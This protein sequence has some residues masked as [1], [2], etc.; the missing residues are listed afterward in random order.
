MN[1]RSPLRDVLGLG[2]AKEGAK[3][4]WWQRVT[5][6][7]LALL[8]VWF[9]ASLICL[10]SLEYA[11][12]TSWIGSPFTTTFLS[13]FIVTLALHSQ[14]GVQ[15]VIEDY[16]HGALKTASIVLS[17]FCHII[18]ATLG[19]VSVLRIAFGSAA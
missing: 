9:V 15:V 7:G 10:G 17:N 18:V 5:A 19:V 12:I 8:G 11:A 14:L 1:L 6:I 3:H 4:W 2:T 13:I 16:V